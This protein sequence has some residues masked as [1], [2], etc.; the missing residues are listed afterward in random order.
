MT[1]HMENAH[2]HLERMT[3]NS[4]NDE[5][6]RTS[7]AMASAEA[8]VASSEA[9]INLA[10]QAR[11]ANL[12]ALENSDLTSGAA[13]AY[14]TLTSTFLEKPHGLAPDIAETLGITGTEHI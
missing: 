14:R 6:I 10:E 5:E 9:L 3:H 7:A 12:I 13:A 11:I 8:A 2:E 1:D 4:H